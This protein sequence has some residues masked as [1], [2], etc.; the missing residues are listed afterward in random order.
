MKFNTAR[1]PV[2]CSAYNVDG[3]LHC[4]IVD[5][6]WHPGEKPFGYYHCKHV[7]IQN[8][9]EPKEETVVE[10]EQQD[11][12]I[13]CKIETLPTEPHYHR[14]QQGKLVACYHVCR[15]VF[16]SPGFWWG[17]TLSFPIEHYL[18]TKVWPFTLITK[19]LGL[20]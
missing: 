19:L 17:T 3:Y 13:N 8:R 16:L 18:Y 5:A 2:G 15:S 7:A 10:Q 12:E 4:K 6:T 9:L 1:A 11:E 14:N 20:D